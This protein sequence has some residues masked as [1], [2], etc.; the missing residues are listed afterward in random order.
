MNKGLLNDGRQ[1][2]TPSAHT[3]QVY[4]NT[5]LEAYIFYDI[6][7]FDIKGKAFPQTLGK[8]YIVDIGLRNYLLGFKDHDRGHV[9]ENVVYFELLRRGYNVSIGI[10]P[11]AV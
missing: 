10:L 4:V 11:M 3:V 6:K 7:R 9:I 1:K 5:L 8:Y 2:G